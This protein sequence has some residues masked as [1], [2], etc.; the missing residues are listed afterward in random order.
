M[1]L[2]VICYI[3]FRR[4]FEALILIK[5]SS[6]YNYGRIEQANYQASFMLESSISPVKS[7]HLHESMT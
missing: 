5:K 4:N 6:N 7:F 2:L 1:N 3:T